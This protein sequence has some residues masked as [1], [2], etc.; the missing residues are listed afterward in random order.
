MGE[1]AQNVNVFVPQS[2]KLSSMRPT[3]GKRE[4]APVGWFWSPHMFCELCA[5]TDTHMDRHI[6]TQTRQYNTNSYIVLQGLEMHL[7]W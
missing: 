5:H 1:V 3:G 4:L 6:Y 7:S 2:G